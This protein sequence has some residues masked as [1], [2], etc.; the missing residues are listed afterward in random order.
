ME[1]DPLLLSRLQFAFLIA[2][3]FL[4]PAF[5]IGLASY[6]AVLEALHWRT[7]R[8]AYLRLSMFWTRIF[9][10]SFGMGVVSGIVMPFQIGTNW[11]GYAQTTANIIAPLMGYEGLTAFFLEAAFL[12]V[13]LFGRALVPKWMH[14][15]SAVI[16]A[17]GT[18]FSA[19]WIL[20]ANSWM[21]TPTGFEIID[22]QFIPTDWFAVIFNPSFPYRFMH[23][24]SA[25]YLTTA[26]T[27]IGVAGYF[28]RRDRYAEEARIMIKM[29]LL[30]AAVFLPVQAVLGDLHGLNTLKHQ[31]AK[32]AAMEAIWDSGPAQPAVILAW[33]DEVAEANRFQVAVPGLASWYLRHDVQGVVQGLKD[34]PPDER[35]PVLP[36][37]LGFRTM[38]AMW[39]LMT[40]L[41]VWG[42]VRVWQGRLPQSH[43]FLRACTWAIP[44][45]YIAVTAG[46][47]TTEVGRQ[48]WVVYGHLRTA[49]AVSPSIT[50]GDVAISLALYVLVYAV[51]FGAGLYYLLYLVRKGLPDGLPAA[52]PAPEPAQ[53]P[54]RPLSGATTPTEGD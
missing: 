3:H 10:L 40:L 49:E 5:T 16:V 42:W 7:G 29:G 24:V 43:R 36:V 46:W 32:L 12:G 25:V 9:A 21:H 53:R 2:F 27:V 11:S 22:G 4:L 39:L 54:A 48:P 31:P 23:T 13:L 17:A 44:S 8:A 18:L 6:I 41:A 38:V 47:I 51:I 26:F 33:P 30:L 14:F 50:G 15:A 52:A 1:L 34:Y 35:P 28:L 45:G 19:F 20:A 37:F